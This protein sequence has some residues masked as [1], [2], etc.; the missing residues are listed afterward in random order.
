METTREATQRRKTAADEIRAAASRAASDPSVEHAERLR[1]MGVLLDPDLEIVSS[2]VRSYGTFTQIER[3]RVQDYVV[4]SLE[5]VILGTGGPREVGE[6]RRVELASISRAPIAWASKYAR[7]CVPGGVTEIRRARARSAAPASPSNGWM[8]PIPSAEEAYLESCE[9]AVI[10]E[11]ADRIEGWDRKK[12][13]PH[14]IEQ[15]TAAELLRLHGLPKP[16]TAD[17]RA[18]RR[19][20]SLL[21]RED[22][23]GMLARSLLHML[24]IIEGR[25]VPA[26]EGPDH[27]LLD[28]WV[29]YT[30][31]DARALLEE[32]PLVI[33]AI[34]RGTVVMPSRPSEAQRRELRRAAKGLSSARGWSSLMQQTEAAWVAEHFASRSARDNRSPL[35]ESQAERIR[36][37]AAGH[38]EESAMAVLSFKGQPL[39]RHVQ[40]IADVSDWFFG[41]LEMVRSDGSELRLKQAA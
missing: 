18:R 25:V 9:N 23:P 19:I 21:D 10:T 22:A 35:N 40:T 41:A 5:R 26:G 4:R 2:A 37:A 8:P 28:L 31:D 29:D 3:D 16:F 13:L 38:W 17:T 30:V 12:M 34:V 14:E 32:G 24:A 33:A 6:R 15:E 36:A 27:D 7:S 1:I 20:S 11:I 39:G